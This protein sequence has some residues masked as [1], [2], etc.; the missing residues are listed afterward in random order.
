MTREHTIQPISGAGMVVLALLLV[1][2]GIFAIALQAPFAAG[3]IFLIM[4]LVL[5]G[6]IIINPNEAIVLVLFGTYT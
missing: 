2:A 1:V 4:P 6:F 5:R 3:V